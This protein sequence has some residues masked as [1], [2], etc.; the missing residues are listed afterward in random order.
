MYNVL[1]IFYIQ[2]L[3][4]VIFLTQFHQLFQLLQLLY[5]MLKPGQL[6]QGGNIKLLVE[7]K[8]QDCYTVCCQE[9][10]TILGYVAD[11]EVSSQ[12][13][14]VVELTDNIAGELNLMK[15]RP[16]VSVRKLFCKSEYRY[17]NVLKFFYQN[18]ISIEEMIIVGDI[19]NVKC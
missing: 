7:Q 2:D 6:K 5:T 17:Q 4:I 16:I 10:M 3:K 1:I 18:F 12:I 19:G 11:D 15:P 13:T 14:T 8:R 9:V